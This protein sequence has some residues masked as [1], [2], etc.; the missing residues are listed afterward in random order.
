LEFVND[1]LELMCVP[2]EELLRSFEASERA[3]ASPRVSDETSQHRIKALKACY[4]EGVN[5][6][7][8]T[9]EEWTTVEFAVDS[10][11]TD[12]VMNEEALECV[13]TKPGQAFRQGVKYEVANGVRIANE[14]EKEF[15]GVSNEGMI[16][17]IKAQVCAVTKSLLSVKRIV[18]AG[19]RV[20]FDD[21]SYIEDKSSGERMKLEE[22]EGMYMVKLWVKNEGV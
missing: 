1:D 13:E 10:G 2:E 16:R 15:T 20:V 21:E 8:A 17:S 18:G 6:L 3:K 5:A 7:N 14:G 4:P 22:K 9:E 11:A 19:H 12:T